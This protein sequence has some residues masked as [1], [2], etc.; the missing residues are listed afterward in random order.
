MR[1]SPNNSKVL[2]AMERSTWDKHAAIFNSYRGADGQAIDLSRAQFGVAANVM[3]GWRQVHLHLDTFRNTLG[4]PLVAVDFGCGSGGFAQQLDERGDMVYGVDLSPSMLTNA[5]ASSP[6]SVYFMTG[7][8]TALRY[9]SHSDA[10]VANLVVNYLPD[11][12]S[13]AANARKA[14]APG[15]LLL[16]VDLNPDYVRECLRREIIYSNPEPPENPRHATLNFAAGPQHITIR[17]QEEYVELFARHGFSLV[18]AE[19]PPLHQEFLDMFAGRLPDK[20]P[21][22]IP[23]YGVYVFRAVN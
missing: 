19:R 17:D 13:F 10:V 5:K 2:T 15:G 22:D 20:Y 21:Q 23:R 11:L 9:F 1:L 8:E 4:K 6:K 18:S 14:L 3:V 12:T 16:F 7:D